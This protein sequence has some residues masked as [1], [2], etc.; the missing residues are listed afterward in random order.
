[1]KQYENGAELRGAAGGVGK[2]ATWSSVLSGARKCIQK[3]KTLTLRIPRVNW[4]AF[5]ALQPGEQTRVMET[6]EA[7]QTR[8][9]GAL[10]KLFETDNTFDTDERAFLREAVNEI[11]GRLLRQAPPAIQAFFDVSILFCGRTQLG[12]VPTADGTLC[13]VAQLGAGL[14]RLTGDR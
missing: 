10:H 9:L 3:K 13:E 2:H 5:S 14:P 8:H 11:L 7:A 4:A 12:Q 6:T 1:M